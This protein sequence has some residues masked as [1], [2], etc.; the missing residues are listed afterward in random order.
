M[1][2]MIVFR[3]VY[4]FER[5]LKT[6]H[7]ANLAKLLLVMSLIWFYLTFSE[8][9][10]G[11]F[12]KEPAELAVIMYK[13]TGPYAIL[14]WTMIF[15]NFVLPVALLSRSRTRTIPFILIVSIGI[16]IGMWLERLIIV[17]PSLSVPYVDFPSHPYL[18]SWTEVSIFAGAL[19]AFCLGF[20]VFAKLFPLISVW[21]VEEGRKVAVEDT[22]KRISG[23][24]PDPAGPIGGRNAVPERAR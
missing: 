13:F 10:T 11:F 17:V 21:E 12:G 5:Y 3:K 22:T 18:P 9:L 14:F 4:H 15:L 24:L 7:F 23:Y 19:A 20:M 2:V 1:V 6:V 16:V 8:Y